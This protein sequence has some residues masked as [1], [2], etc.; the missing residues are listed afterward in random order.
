ME[1]DGCTWIPCS[2]QYNYGKNALA[3]APS[4]EA[5]YIP[6]KREKVEEQKTK[7]RQTEGM[8]ECSAHLPARIGNLAT[9]LANCII[10]TPVS[11]AVLKGGRGGSGDFVCLLLGSQSRVWMEI[12]GKVKLR[13]AGYAAVYP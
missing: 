7:K 11:T 12:R 5:L 1:V 9:S 8:L 2:R 13:V 10:A 6:Y 3:P 4:G